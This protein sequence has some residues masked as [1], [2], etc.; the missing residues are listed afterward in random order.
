MFIELRTPSR[1]PY[2]VV[3]LINFATVLEKKVG[4]NSIDI[5]PVR[6][7]EIPYIEGSI[8]QHSFP[9]SDAQFSKA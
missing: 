3:N 4:K 6:I 1:A 7:L 5:Q 9:L 8:L 2:A